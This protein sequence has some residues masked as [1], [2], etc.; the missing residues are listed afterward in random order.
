V[1]L[2]RTIPCRRA[3]GPLLGE[4]SQTLT[5]GAGSPTLEAAA[6]ALGL[7]TTGRME[8]VPFERCALGD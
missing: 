8:L 3:G 5:A 2:G 6:A 7:S 1:D 4:R